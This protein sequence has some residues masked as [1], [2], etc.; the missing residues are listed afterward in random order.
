[1]AAAVK[2]PNEL[3][4]VA[5]G[6]FA[7]IRASAMRP[8]KGGRAISPITAPS[9]GER[10]PTTAVAA[11]VSVMIGTSGPAKKLAGIATREKRPKL[12]P[13]TGAAARLAASV[14]EALR[15]TINPAQPG[16]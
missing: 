4:S 11:D 15:A 16:I 2:V 6:A 3:P 10:A 9:G 14:T 5:P 12:A 13:I 1:M 8:L 7:N